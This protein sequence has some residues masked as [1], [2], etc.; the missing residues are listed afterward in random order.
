MALRPRE[1]GLSGTDPS[2]VSSPIIDLPIEQL[3]RNFEMG[4]I[5]YLRMMQA[6]H[7]HLKASGEGR[8][9][10][11]ASLAGVLGSLAPDGGM[12]IDSAR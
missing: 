2:A 3:Q 7:P 1:R 12:I 6:C 9:I 11:F 5:A 8:V 4:P 10:N